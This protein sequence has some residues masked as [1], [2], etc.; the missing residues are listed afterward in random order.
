MTGKQTPVVV[1]EVV[2][3]VLL[4]V[5]VVVAVEDVLVEVVVLVAVVAP[6]EVVV[7]VVCVTLLEVLGGDVAVEEV[8]AALEEAPRLELLEVEDVPDWEVDELGS[9]EDDPGVEELDAPGV[10]EPPWG[11]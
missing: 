3:V 6:V 4:V 7:V 1:V 8:E 9:P 11:T 2:E 10:A 5:V